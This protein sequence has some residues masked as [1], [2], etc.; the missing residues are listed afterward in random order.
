MAS[1][2]DPAANLSIYAAT[3]S[4]PHGHHRGA[5]KRVGA[6][7]DSRELH[8]RRGN[9][10]PRALARLALIGVGS[11]LR[12]ANDCHDAT[13]RV[14]QP[15]EH[16]ADRQLFLASD[17]SSWLTGERISGL[18]GA[19]AKPLSKRKPE[20]RSLNRAT[21][22]IHMNQYKQPARVGCNRQVGKL[23]AKILKKE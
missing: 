8:Q 9:G 15:S 4:A 3:K 1:A 6:E 23:V 22:E 5:R 16:R 14:G 20:L 11:E 13:R 19:G 7:T 18:P 2:I 17:E 10:K 12:E 21:K